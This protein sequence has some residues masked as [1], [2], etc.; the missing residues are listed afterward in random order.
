MAIGSGRGR[1]SDINVTPFVDVM[2]VLLV[3]FMIASPMMF[4]GISLTLPKTKKIHNLNLSDKQVILSLSPAGEL[5]L[6]K[7]KILLSEMAKL[8]KERLQET[9]N[10]VI[11]IRAH[12]NLRYGRVAEI[13]AHL[14]G[15]GFQELALVT[16]IKQ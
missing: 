4:N 8:I 16:E 10:Q 2:L 6:G 15:S 3:I 9:K 7:D 14:K 12:R 13:M 5:Y 11:Y 1:F